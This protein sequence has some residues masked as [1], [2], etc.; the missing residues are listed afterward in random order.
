[1]VTWDPPRLTVSLRNCRVVSVAGGSAVVAVDGRQ[2]PVPVYGQAVAGGGGLLLEQ[3]SSL[4]LL[5]TGGG[6]GGLDAAAADAR[7]VNV[8]GDVMTGALTVL[9][10]TVAGHAASKGYVDA[11]T[12]PVLVLAAGAPVPPGTAAGT[13]VVRPGAQV[14]K[15]EVYVGPA[16]PRTPVDIWADTS[17]G[18][19]RYRA[20]DGTYRPIKPR[21]Y[22]DL[23]DE[24][25]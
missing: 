20:E 24:E 6:G 12:P 3:G 19:V 13:V 23:Y 8:S 21:H 2:V 1:M 25:V 4:L 17:T 14:V 11:R 9:P 5:G 22:A 10:P 7:Y 15:E 18:T 16:V